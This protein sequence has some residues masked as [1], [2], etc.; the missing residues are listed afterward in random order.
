MAAQAWPDRV[1][2]Y[3]QASRVLIVILSDFQGLLTDW[4]NRSDLTQ[5]QVTFLVD[6]GIARCQR[7][8]RLPSMERTASFP[9]YQQTFVD[10]VT[11]VS[12][13]GVFLR[14]FPIPDDLIEIEY[15]AADN[16]ILQPV[17][18]HE[19][20]RQPQVIGQPRVFSRYGGQI[21]V[22]PFAQAYCQVIYY[23]SFDTLSAG[24][25]TNALLGASPEVLLYA[26]LSYAG[27]LFRMDEAQTWE[28]RFQAEA[29]VLRQQAMDTDLGGGPAA[30]GSAFPRADY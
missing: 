14:Q 13:S 30:I 9:P 29:Q 22:A 25:D 23:G 17:Q 15:L 6:R 7:E 16:V 2:D 5:Q 19:Y 12:T 24:T 1:P 10:P 18:Y 4:L 11:N 21:F 3:R 28:Q 26:C 20:M 27:D 8:L